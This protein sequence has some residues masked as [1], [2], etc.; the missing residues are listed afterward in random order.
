MSPD[1]PS[2]VVCK[3]PDRLS[4]GLSR[5]M[6]WGVFFH[7]R[8]TTRSS[9][10]LLLP[11]T[12]VRAGMEGATP[13]LVNKMIC[14]S[15]GWFAVPAPNQ[16]VPYLPLCAPIKNGAERADPAFANGRP[17]TVWRGRSCEIWGVRK[18][19]FQLICRRA[20]CRIWH[21]CLAGERLPWFVSF[22]W[23]TRTEDPFRLASGGLGGRE[24]DESGR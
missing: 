15:I 20:A 6:A 12:S 5:A 17:A 9:R 18:G 7:V 19:F 4:T 24:G 11:G 16:V 3:K 1:P 21:K 23:N 22:G 8:G 14:V 10:W 13:V 2:T